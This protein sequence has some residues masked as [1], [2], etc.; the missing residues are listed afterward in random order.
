M[1]VR[2]FYKPHLSVSGTDLSAY[3]TALT[4]NYEGEAHDITAG[5]DTREYVVGLRNWSFEATFNQDR[6]AGAV[7][8]TLF[9]LVGAESFAV[10]IREQ[11]DAVSQTNPQYTGNALLLSYPVISGTVGRVE[12]PAV[13]FQ[14]SGTLT[15]SIS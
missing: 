7:D 11:T 4:L 14:G 6:A 15:R 5:S 2:T 13:R 3:V 1:A 12:Q 10:V 8:A 9:P